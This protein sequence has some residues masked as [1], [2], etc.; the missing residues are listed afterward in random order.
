MSCR[1]S[2]GTGLVKTSLIRSR[3]DTIPSLAAVRTPFADY[4]SMPICDRRLNRRT[5]PRD[6]DACCNYL[7]C[8][9]NIARPIWRMQTRR[10]V[11]RLPS[12]GC[13]EFMLSK[14]APS[15]VQD[16]EGFEVRFCRRTSLF[17]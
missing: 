4:R 13:L 10:R 9:K 8:S 1:R 2:N 7:V 5:D 17:R 3:R 16:L 15:Q 6:P 14:T 11:L 12:V